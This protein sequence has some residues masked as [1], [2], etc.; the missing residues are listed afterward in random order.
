VVSSL[1]PGE[2]QRLAAADS[3]MVP[4]SLSLLFYGKAVVPPHCQR[5]RELSPW[6][7]KRVT[8][9]R[10]L[11]SPGSNLTKPAGTDLPLWP[12]ACPSC[13][14]TELSETGSRSLPHCSGQEGWAALSRPL[15]MVRFFSFWERGSWGWCMPGLLAWPGTTGPGGLG[16]SHPLGVIFLLEEVRK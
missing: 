15:V 10:S 4:I 1:F 12:P 2:C 9:N 13:L 8:N 11:S 6:F 5:C 14:S 16:K 3:G 7:P